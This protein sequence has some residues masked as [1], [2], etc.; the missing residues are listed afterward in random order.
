MK[1]R[2]KLKEYRPKTKETFSCAYNQW[3]LLY[4]DNKA[5]AKLHSSLDKKNPLSP[6]IFDIRNNNEV[7]I[8]LS[9]M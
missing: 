2:L 6:Y 1:R 9:K 5:L 4:K 3:I 8:L 7:F